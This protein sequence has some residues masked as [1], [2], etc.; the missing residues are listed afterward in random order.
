MSAVCG[1]CLS[2]D[3]PQT[4]GGVVGGMNETLQLWSVAGT[5]FAGFCT[6]AAV[7]FSLWLAYNKDKIKL[8]V[9]A[10]KI[11]REEN[12]LFPSEGCWIRVVNKGSMPAQITKIGWQVGSRKNMYFISDEEESGVIRQMLTAGQDKEY[13]LRA[14]ELVMS[15]KIKNLDDN[16]RNSR[17]DEILKNINPLYVVVCVAANEQPFKAKVSDNMIKELIQMWREDSGLENET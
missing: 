3:Q 11:A 17:I 1:G 5:W 15:G 8:S 4:R 13:F 6:L 10:E 9:K 16:V 2:S 14:Y 7:V 12:A